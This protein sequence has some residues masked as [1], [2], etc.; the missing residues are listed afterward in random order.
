VSTDTLIAPTT[1]VPNH[2]HQAPA[3]R[4][5]HV[6]E[7]YIRD[8]TVSD[9]V[10]PAQREINN[11]WVNKIMTDFDPDAFGLVTVNKRAD[12]SY[13]IV[14]GQHRIEAMRLLGWDDQKVD[15]NIY[16]GLS[17]K[18]EAELFL[19]LN[20][21]LAVPAMATFKVG[22]TAGRTEEVAINEILDGLDLRVGVGRTG[23]TISAVGTLRRIYRRYGGEVL[24]RSLSI[25]KAAF[26]DEGFTTA[27]IDGMAMFVA[28]YSETINDDRITDTLGRVNGGA[29][30]L[31]G[32]AETLRATTGQPKHQCVGAAIVDY[33]N[34]GRG[35]RKL[36]NWW[37]VE[38]AARAAS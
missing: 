13:A 27:V 29:R 1:T 36:R 34:A 18:Q 14:D 24:S 5:S 10:D 17:L 15:A 12:G 35:G 25:V 19:L 8:M 9:A 6:G 2:D 16:E 20:K 21:R 37:A 26:G 11:D 31:L 28:R 23:G 7:V 3:T 33:V 38:E 32:R 30:G 22:V 4:A